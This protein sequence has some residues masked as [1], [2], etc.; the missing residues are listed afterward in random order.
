VL[1]LLS[2]AWVIFALPLALWVA[3]CLTAGALTAA[4]AGEPTLLLSGVAGAVMQMAWS[5][6]FW[7]RLLANGAAWLRAWI[8]SRR[9][10][11]TTTGED[12]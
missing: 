9:I 8:A 12:L 3:A 6:G 11:H 4:R 10:S 7:S 5:L 1:A 2:I